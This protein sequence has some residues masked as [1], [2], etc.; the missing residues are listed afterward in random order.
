MEQEKMTFEKALERLEKIVS[1][2]EAGK[3]SLEESIERY[4]EGIGLIKRCR[5]I[6]AT[7]EQKIKL[8]TKGEGTS[9]EISGEL[10]EDEDKVAT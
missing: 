2:I 9:L 7:A 3:V 8:L 4:A 6:L 5:A 1:E 10:E